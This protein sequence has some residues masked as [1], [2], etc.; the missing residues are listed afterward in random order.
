MVPHALAQIMEHVDNASRAQ[1]REK[2]D[3]KLC[4]RI[5]RYHPGN[6]DVLLLANRKTTL[7]LKAP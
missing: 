5:V 3:L 7:R 1:W 4:T 2:F 6:G